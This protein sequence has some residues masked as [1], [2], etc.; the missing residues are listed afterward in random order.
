MKRLLP[1]ALLAAGAAADAH[2][3]CE[4]PALV[5]IPPA[6]EIDGEEATVEQETDLYFQRMHEYVS[7]IRA[8]LESAGDDASELYKQV[9]VQRNNVAAA[10][11]FAVQQWYQ[12][13][14]PSAARD[15]SL[16]G[17]A[18]APDESAD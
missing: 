7:C 8:E 12:E 9:L 10:E 15:V 13:R 4:Q 18:G 14:F 17:N 2:A 6:D 11:A 16:R 3:A 1:A 5:V